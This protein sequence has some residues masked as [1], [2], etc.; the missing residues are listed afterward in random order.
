MP[1]SVEGLSVEVRGDGPTVVLVHGTAPP[2]WGRLPALLTPD[3]RVVRY[4]RRS[5]P[6][7]DPG[8]VRS[9][10]AHADD[11]AAL[12]VREGAPATVVAWSIGGVV[13]LDLALRRPDVV[14]GLVLVE[15][16]LHLKRR[17]SPAMMRAVV[18]ARLAGRRRATVGARRFLTWALARSDGG[19]D[20]D[21]FDPADVQRCAP[22]IVAELALGTG[23]RELRP[24]DLARLTVPTR[25]L[26]G[27]QGTA[28]FA[29]SAIRAAAVQ[30][31]LVVEQVPGAG[32]AV[33]LDS[34]DVVAEAVRALEHGELVG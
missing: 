16:A 21:R 31:G 24:R 17:P 27:A 19:N 25:W 28:A 26:V 14:A 20:L 11:L 9:L 23:E 18:G 8:P 13:A 32:H 30:P 12:L 10:R 1:G 5:F 34:P 7:S 2:A 4:H 29:R 33:Q 22:A 6:P 3:H 15:A